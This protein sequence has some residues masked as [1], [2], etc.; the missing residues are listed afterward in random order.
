MSR[1][2][3]P[4]PTPNKPLDSAVTLTLYM[5]WGW[6]MLTLGGIMLLLGSDILPGG[7]AMSVSRAVFHAVSASTLTGFTAAESGIEEFSSWGRTIMLALTG[8]G[9]FVWL[10]LGGVAAKRLAGL[11]ATDGS[12]IV[13]SL[14]MLVVALTVGVLIPPHAVPSMVA[15]VGAVGNS[16]LEIGHVT[17]T[18]PLLHGVLFPLAAAGGLGAVAILD[19]VLL[20]RRPGHALTSFT[21][22]TVAAVAGVFVALTAL[23]FLMSPDDVR[24][25]PRAAALAGTTLGYGLPVEFAT[26]WSRSLQVIATLATTL[27]MGLGGTAGGLSVTTLHI[28]VRGTL[29]A[30]AGRPVRR[31]YFGAALHV[32]ALAA[33]ITLVLL[34]LLATEPQVDAERLFT[35]SAAA[36]S[37]SALSHDPISIVGGGL[38]LL[39]LAMLVGRLLPIAALWT[40]VRFT[41]SETP[42]PPAKR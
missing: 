9:T 42:E 26:N 22:T 15:T 33:W 17:V 1:T 28:L 21:R 10:S 2:P 13:T 27:G 16:G 35:L 36:S 37:N 8:L 7:R 25:L 6:M 38:F 20:F 32:A 12:V 3:L 29:D 31:V 5:G 40:M 11:K 18:E 14:A 23:Y 30:L 41:R 19:V 24:S 39:A 34:A 4:H